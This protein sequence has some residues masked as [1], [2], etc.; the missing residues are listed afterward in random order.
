M[1]YQNPIL[2]LAVI[3]LCVSGCDTDRMCERARLSAYEA[4]DALSAAASQRKLAGVDVDNWEFVESR[5]DLLKS[6][7]ATEQVTWRPAERSRSE[8]KTRLSSIQTTSDDALEI[9]KRSADEA[10]QVQEQFASE[11]R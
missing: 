1:K 3:G 2:F 4:Y 8:M 10:F 5:A 11:C 6:S 9:F 7:F